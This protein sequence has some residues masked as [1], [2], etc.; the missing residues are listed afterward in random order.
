MPAPYTSSASGP[1]HARGGARCETGPGQPAGARRA[2]PGNDDGPAA[3]TILADLFPLAIRGRVLSAFC[4]AIPVG[5]ALGY[6]LGGIIGSHWGWRWAFYVLTPP[7]LVLGLICLFLRDPRGRGADRRQEKKA[8]WN[9]YPKLFR[10][11]YS[12]IICF[13]QTAMTF[14]C[15]GLA[16]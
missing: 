12:A 13:T 11:R 5:G 2:P 7:G 1:P 6:V 9:D 15:G 3:P 4:A 16:F 14:A 8:T 10:T